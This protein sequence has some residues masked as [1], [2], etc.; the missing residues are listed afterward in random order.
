MCVCV[1]SVFGGGGPRTSTDLSAC[2]RL[3]ASL[4]TCASAAYAARHAYGTL[5][6][7]SMDR[8]VGFR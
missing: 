1:S 8:E 7:S 2:F 3:S 6:A 5:A 4:P